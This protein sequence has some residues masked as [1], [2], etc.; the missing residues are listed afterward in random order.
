M[1]KKVAIK[2]RGIQE[3]NRKLVYTKT[4]EGPVMYAYKYNGSWAQLTR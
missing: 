3:G 1:R 2:A 4:K